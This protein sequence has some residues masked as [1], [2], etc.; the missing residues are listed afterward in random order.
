MDSEEHTARLDARAAATDSAFRAFRSK[1]DEGSFRVLYRLCTPRLYALALRLTASHD[2]A[3]D[4]VQET[5][6]RAA[7]SLHSFEGRSRCTTWLTGIAIRCCQERQRSDGKWDGDSAVAFT[8]G[9]TSQAPSTGDPMR[10]SVEAML[11]AL[12]LGFRSVLLLHDL[13]GYT[14][15]EIAGLLSIDEGTSK[16]QLSRARSAARRLLGGSGHQA[17]EAS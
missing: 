1:R 14:H 4:V 10:S 11:R 6:L 7:R 8:E 9:L 2:A 12:P 5:W 17:G 3:E 13:Y 16:S 15:A